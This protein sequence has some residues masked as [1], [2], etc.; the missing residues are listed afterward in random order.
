MS[1]INARDLELTIRKYCN[2]R[3]I[4]EEMFLKLLGE[5]IEHLAKNNPKAT[6]KEIIAELEKRVEQK[7]SNPEVTGQQIS[8][9]LRPNGAEERRYVNAFEDR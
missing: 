5:S 1:K 4:N 8:L 2:K 3:E 9:C 7:R 6:M